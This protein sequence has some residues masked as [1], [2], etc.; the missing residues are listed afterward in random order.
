MNIESIKIE[1]QIKKIMSEAFEW[2]S[3]Y[4]KTGSEIIIG[5]YT[6]LTRYTTLDAI[7]MTLYKLDKEELI[8]YK[9]L[10]IDKTMI[11][12]SMYNNYKKKTS[13][14]TDSQLENLNYLDD[15]L[16]DL[17]TMESRFK[18][19][20]EFGISLLVDY[21]QLELLP[22]KEKQKIEDYILTIVDETAIIK[23]LQ[24]IKW[25]YNCD[26][27]ATICEEIEI[28]Y[29][30]S[31]GKDEDENKEDYEEKEYFEDYAEYLQ[32]NLIDNSHI[33]C[34]EII[35][36][37]DVNFP[38]VK[39]QQKFIGH[40]LSVVYG[41]LVIDN[42]Y[43]KSFVEEYL[44]N[45]F[46]D[47]N[48]D[49]SGLVSKFYTDEYFLTYIIWILYD[50]LITQSSLEDYRYE[51]CTLK[52]KK[53]YNMLD[54]TYKLEFDDKY[55]YHNYSL[56]DTLICLLEKINYNLSNPVRNQ[57]IYQIITQPQSLREYLIDYEMNPKNELIYRDAILRLICGLYVEY[58][59]FKHGNNRENEICQEILSSDASTKSLAQ[60]FDNNFNSIINNYYEYICLPDEIYNS[61]MNNIASKRL[62]EKVSLINP[63]CTI[64]YDEL[65]ETKYQKQKKRKK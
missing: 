46:N 2:S 1:E 37:L 58:R 60:I 14:L 29:F 28:K 19:D 25:Q 15:E 56:Q 26:D 31:S 13:K 52:N 16:N 54:S 40:L 43:E 53:M 18:S 62:F 27:I 6:F 8:T 39:L 47:P 32:L 42:T 45:I 9:L 11:N 30:N 63:L 35:D 4:N 49:A 36:Y 59:M 12:F 64:K 55:I 48:A 24:E 22:N 61:C 51:S 17:A 38:N 3:K 23:Y 41:Y 5:I 20:L 34:N 57:L 44:L 50:Q 33:F 65:K 7:I 21:Y 10:C